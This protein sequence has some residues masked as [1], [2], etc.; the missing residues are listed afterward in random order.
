M[1]QRIL[2]GTDIILGYLLNEEYADG[3]S[4]V[5]QWAKRLNAQQLLDVGTISITTHFVKTNRLSALKGFE[6]IREMPPLLAI[7]KMMLSQKDLWQERDERALLMQLNLI[8][9]N[10]ADIL[11]TENLR[12]HELSRICSMDDKVFTMDEFIETCSIEHRDKDDSKGIILKEVSFGTLSLDDNFFN[13]FKREYA[14]YYYEWFK[15]KKDDLVYVAKDENDKIKA[16]LKLKLELEDEDYSTII[17]LLPPARRLKISSLKVDYSGQKI[18][19]RFMRI[20]FEQALK[21]KVDEIYVT[22]YANNTPRLR[23]IDMIK[24]WGFS[25]WGK[26]KGGE[27]V[28]IRTM[29][30]K[31]LPLPRLSYPFQDGKSN[32]F[33]ITVGK[34]YSKLLIPSK[35]VRENS[36]DMEPF[37][38]AIRKMIILKEDNID[39]KPGS[40]ILFFRKG[41]G[42]EEEGIIGAGIVDDVFQSFNNEE[43]FLVRCRKRT[44]LSSDAL[45]SRWERE[46]GKV[47][48]IYFLHNASF[49][50]KPI[51]ISSLSMVG[52]DMMRLRS[53]R[54]LPIES[55]QFRYLIKGTEYEEDLVV[56]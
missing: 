27:D 44:S 31:T 7:F 55:N 2:F 13:T 6:V 34:G 36:F 51:S 53:T 33:I 47:K 45:H 30:K 23:L 15:K 8:K 46:E 18:G 21:H 17:P 14:P 39:I 42:G 29:K 20:I 40:A 1:N 32:V 28:Y 49:Y 35:S 26:K 41:S 52:I 12:A 54:C 5:Q 50:M 11:V 25:Y 48:V 19:E 3:V 43:E 37:R 16:L 38:N 4:V 56:D 22:V 24:R 10:K 9:Y